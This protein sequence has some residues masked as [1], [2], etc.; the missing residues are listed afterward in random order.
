[1]CQDKKLLEEYKD[2][3]TMSVNNSVCN[4]QQ[5]LPRPSTLPCELPWPY[6]RP[7]ALYLVNSYSFANNFALNVIRGHQHAV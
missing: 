6:Y 7:R 5:C 3:Q 2:L 1:M 4:L